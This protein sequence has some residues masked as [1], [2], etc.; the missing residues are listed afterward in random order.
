MK[1]ESKSA[2]AEYT[3]SGPEKETDNYIVISMTFSGRSIKI[4][5]LKSY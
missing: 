5:A 3:N 4:R 2:P 1:T